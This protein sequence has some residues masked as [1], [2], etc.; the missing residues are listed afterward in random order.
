LINLRTFGTTGITEDESLEHSA[1]L[2]YPDIIA[3]EIVEDLQSRSR[4]V[5]RNRVGSGEITVTLVQALPDWQ[6][7]WRALRWVLTHLNTH[8][9]AIT[10]IIL[11]PMALWTFWI[12]R[13]SKKKESAEWLHKLFTNFYLSKD[14][15][16]LRTA[17]EF[18]SE[19]KLRPVIE[20]ILIDE[21]ADADDQERRALCDI[22][23]LLNY[24]EFIL[25]LEQQN[26]IKESDCDQLFSYWF[27]VLKKP[28]LA[29]LR[30]YCQRFGYEAICKR[31][32]GGKKCSDIPEHVA[33]YGSLM[34]DCG[35]QEELQIKDCLESLGPCE[36]RGR[37]Y[38]LGEYP[39]LVQGDDRVKAELY[40]VKDL[41]VFPLLDKY[42][43]FDVR[44]QERSLFVRHVVRLPKPQVDAWVYFYNRSIDSAPRS[45]LPKHANSES[46]GEQSV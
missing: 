42:E 23:T 41:R 22:D 46:V 16:P 11:V 2:P 27:S 13:K 12:Y 32:T 29:Y 19:A 8:K 5:R 15:D 39:G 7:I 43:E 38:D 1:N 28:E 37:L 30:L 9:D 45:P 44:N 40:K 4:S 31:V 36:I 35:K 33:F 17:I 34:K 25:Y 21:N 6:T 24:F 18:D 10:I 14:V 3:A 26:Q 20:R